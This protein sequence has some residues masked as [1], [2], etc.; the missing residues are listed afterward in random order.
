LLIFPC[1]LKLFFCPVLDTILYLLTKPTL[2]QILIRK[3]LWAVVRQTY[4]PPLNILSTLCAYK[5]W[6]LLSLLYCGVLFSTRLETSSGEREG[7]CPPWLW[8]SH[9]VK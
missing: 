7:R 3:T 9:H 1:L 8:S 6:K 2:F 4:C 5:Y